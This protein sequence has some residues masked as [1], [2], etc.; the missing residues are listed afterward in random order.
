MSNKVSMDKTSKECSISSDLFRQLYL[1]SIIARFSRGSYGS[2]RLHKITYITERRQEKLRP[3]EF[4]KYHYGQYS[5]TLEE[6]KDQLITLGLVNAIPLDTS[7]K[8]TFK[9]PDGKATEWYEGG[10]RYTI[11]NR[12]AVR[13]F[14][15]AFKEISP[16]LLS[17]I[18]STVKKFG[19]LPEQELIE[20]CYAFPEFNE[21]E[22]GETIFESNLPDRIE[23]PSLGEDECEE[24][25]MALSPKF[26]LAMKRV[27][28]GMDNSK[29]DLGRV[30][31]VEIPIQIS[32]A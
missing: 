28:E 11:S 10:V 24:L 2:K 6:T 22:F 5:E 25:E 4:K 29:L 7:L 17:T 14:I 16:D 21:A 3:F 9:L 23:V 8:M 13:F 19:Y 20:Q 27:V 31:E 1:L 30:K 18:Y 32:R 15:D 12:D 26:I